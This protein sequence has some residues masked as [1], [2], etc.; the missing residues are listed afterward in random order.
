M[1][2]TYLFLKKLHTPRFQHS[3]LPAD[4]YGWEFFVYDHLAH[5]LARGFEQGG[6]FFN[7]HFSCP[8]VLSLCLRSGRKFVVLLL[9]VD[10]VVQFANQDLSEAVV[11]IQVFL[12]GNTV[13]FRVVPQ[14][15]LVHLE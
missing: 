1:S 7:R 5:L 13:L 8:G 9:F 2:V 3:P 12:R 11:A 14:F 10:V 4:L 6:G 15:F